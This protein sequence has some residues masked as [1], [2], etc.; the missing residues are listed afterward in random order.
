VALLPRDAR[1]PIG[2]DCVLGQN[3]FIGANVRFATECTSRTTSPSMRRRAGGRSLLRSVVCVHERENRGPN[4]RR[5]DAFLKTLVRRGATI[6]GKCQDRVRRDD[7]SVAMIG[8]GAVITKDVVDYALMT[9]VPAKREGW[10]S[11]RGHR[12]G[13]PISHVLKLRP[14]CRSRRDASPE[15]DRSCSA[16]HTCHLV[17]RESLESHGSVVLG[18]VSVLS[19]CC[20]CRAKRLEDR[21]YGHVHGRGSR[22]RCHAGA[23]TLSAHVDAGWRSQLTLSRVRGTG[24]AHGRCRP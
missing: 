24:G 19:V 2:R 6:G 23:C 16:I 14:L 10:V 1:R 5:K 13:L 8:A 11:R 4:S 3:V 9:G 7:R 17:G 12:P 21:R 18:W 22:A 20:L 15:G